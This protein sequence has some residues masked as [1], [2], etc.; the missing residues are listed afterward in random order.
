[1]K[2]K[3][4]AIGTAL[5]MALAAPAHAGECTCGS[6]ADRSTPA[7]VQA[8]APDEKARHPLRGEVIRVDPERQVVLV[9][10]EEIPGYMRAMTMQF[11]VPPE[12]LRLME[13]GQKIKATLVHRSDGF[14]LE[15]VQVLE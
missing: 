11:K 14:W 1:M 4:A 9:R 6:K 8:A 2:M 7:P 3:Q 10:H 13:K 15:N 5:V 12:T